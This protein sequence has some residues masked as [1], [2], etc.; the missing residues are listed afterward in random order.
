MPIGRRWCIPERRTQK[1]VGEVES[2]VEVKA[3]DRTGAQHSALSET[4]HWQQHCGWDLELM[5]NG[6]AGVIFIFFNARTSSW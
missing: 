1:A 5:R 4:Q 3:Q 6:A 2:E